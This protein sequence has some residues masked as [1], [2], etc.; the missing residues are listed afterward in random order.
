MSFDFDMDKMKDP[1]FRSAM[2]SKVNNMA[3]LANEKLSC[4]PA[5]ERQRKLDTLKQKLDRA[6]E[7]K[8]DIPN[9]FNK[10]EKNYYIFA[11]GAPYYDEMME[12]RYEATANDIMKKR[13]NEHKQQMDILQEELT[14]YINGTLYEQNIN[15]LLVKYEQE[16]KSY[17]LNTLKMKNNISISDRQSLYEDAETVKKTRTRNILFFI[18]YF[19]VFVFLVYLVARKRYK[20]IKLLVIFA[21]MLAFPFINT[22]IITKINYTINMIKSYSS[23]VYLDNNSNTSYDPV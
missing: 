3:K 16:D 22:Y 19:V 14:S 1:A 15:D 20:E 17:K 4:D 21:I 11:K 5:C 12:S 7:V 2:L 9:I 8:K 18:Y 13:G 10:A 6:A 23:D